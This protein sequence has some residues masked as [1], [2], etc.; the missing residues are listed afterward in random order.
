MLK[1]AFF[2]ANTTITKI[3]RA[4]ALDRYGQSQL[5]TIYRNVRG[6]LSQT[7]RFSRTTQ[8]DSFLLDGSLSL[9]R[10]FVL[11]PKDKIT[12]GDKTWIIFTTN[13]VQDV[14]GKVLFRT[15]GLTKQK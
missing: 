12:V 3:E 14:H 5:E 10:R 2:K 13:E 1:S 9:D 6:R 11:Q 15:Y 8:G 7:T 4:G